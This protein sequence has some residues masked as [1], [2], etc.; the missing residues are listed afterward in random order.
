MKKFKNI[1]IFMLGLIILPTACTKDF[2]EINTDPNNPTDAPSINIMTNVIR[3]HTQNWYDP[4][5]DMNE[6]SCYA[7]HLGKIQYIDEAA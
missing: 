7:N 4:W 5:G 6:P 1:F 2:E 3:Y